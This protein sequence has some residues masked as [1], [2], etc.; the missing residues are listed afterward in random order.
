MQFLVVLAVKDKRAH[1]YIFVYT[2]T[3]TLLCL[4]EFLSKQVFV[5][6]ELIYSEVI[7]SIVKS[8]FKLNNLNLTY[9]IRMAHG[10][11]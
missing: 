5:K 11:L 6:F 9:K 8:S 1:L 2:H 3:R 4:R 7:I 10:V